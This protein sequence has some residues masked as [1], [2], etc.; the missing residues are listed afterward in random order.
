MDPKVGILGAPNAGVILKE[1][2]RE[3]LVAPKAGVPE[4]PKDGVLEIPKAVPVL[5]N[6][7]RVRASNAGGKCRTKCRFFLAL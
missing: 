5:L 1:P 7:E 4:D 6:P 3:E 2:I